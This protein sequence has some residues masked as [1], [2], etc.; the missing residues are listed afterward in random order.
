M[1]KGFALAEMLAVLMLLPVAM[2]VA[3]GLFH[4]LS[5][6]VPR[7]SQMIQE[8]T[9]VLNVVDRIRKDV[10]A[11][12][13]L[14]DNFEHRMSDNRTLLI[15]LPADVVCYQLTDGGITRQNLTGGADA[16]ETSWSLPNSN[17]TWNLRLSDGKAYAVELRTN[18]RYRIRKEHYRK[19]ANSH[20]FFTGLR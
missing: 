6:E 1:R 9:T 4:T 15:E 16:A 20:V 13:R 19:M 5:T 8:H 11:A 12:E 10:V 7:H 17:F 2:L 3:A 18:I 14:L